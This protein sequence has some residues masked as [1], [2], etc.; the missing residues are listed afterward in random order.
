MLFFPHG[1]VIYIVALDTAQTS[2]DISFPSLRDVKIGVVSPFRAGP[3]REDPW[4]TATTASIAAYD[5]MVEV[6][7]VEPPPA[8]WR[9]RFYRPR[10][11]TRHSPH[12][13]S[14]P[15]RTGIRRVS[16]PLPARG[17]DECRDMG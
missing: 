13:H 11:L 1:S 2:V 17:S 4:C 15:L 6:E 3:V 5:D 9:L 8:R 10:R 16:H 7:G 12:F 14:I